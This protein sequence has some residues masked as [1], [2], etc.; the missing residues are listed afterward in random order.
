[1]NATDEEWPFWARLHPS[2]N[3][4]LPELQ[5]AYSFSAV[6]DV[7]LIISMLD[8]EFCLGLS[9]IDRDRLGIPALL[10]LGWP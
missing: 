8:Y 10:G 2:C 4:W 7:D 6:D 9:A 1:M 3:D 5:Q